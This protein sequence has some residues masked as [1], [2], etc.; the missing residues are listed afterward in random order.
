MIIAKFWIRHF[1]KTLIQSYGNIISKKDLIVIKIIPSFDE[2]S[3]S[4]LTGFTDHGN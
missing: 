1:L 3:F 4:F 2:T